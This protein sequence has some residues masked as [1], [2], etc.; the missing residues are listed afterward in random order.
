MLR[1]G[2]GR[3]GGEERGITADPEVRTA[4]GRIQRC[5][6]AVRIQRHAAA[7]RGRR[8]DGRSREACWRPVKGGAQAAGRGRSTTR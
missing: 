6:A 8:A 1:K 7:G 3:R 4:A 2:M 5:T